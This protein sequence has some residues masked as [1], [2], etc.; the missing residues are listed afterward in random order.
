MAAA[1]YLYMNED[2]NIHGPFWLSQMRDLW[3]KGKLR[4]STEICMEGATKWDRIE[5]YPEIYESEARL[6]FFSNMRKAKSDP[7]RLVAWLI[8]LLL[9]FAVYLMQRYGAK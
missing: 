8:V 6:P 4:D 5:F 2:G 1:R 7:G 9:G 3:A